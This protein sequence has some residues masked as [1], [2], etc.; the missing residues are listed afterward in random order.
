MADINS[1]KQSYKA[2]IPLKFRCDQLTKDDVTQ[3][4]ALCDVEMKYDNKKTKYCDWDKLDE[5]EEANN[6]PT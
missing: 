4:W 5:Q 3:Q 2:H 1:N 6:I